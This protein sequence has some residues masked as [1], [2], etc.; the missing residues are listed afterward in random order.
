MGHE[1]P[2]HAEEV[3]H[4]SCFWQR[5]TLA[6]EPRSE[7]VAFFHCRRCCHHGLTNLYPLPSHISSINLLQKRC[8][9]PGVVVAHHP[10]GPRSVIRHQISYQNKILL[11]YPSRSFYASTLYSRQWATSDL[12]IVQATLTEDQASHV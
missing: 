4:C 1:S 3:R 12:A 6:T 2:F 11:L 5:A 10:I 9:G 7:S 8:R